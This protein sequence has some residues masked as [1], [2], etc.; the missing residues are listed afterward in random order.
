MRKAGDNT[1]LVFGMSGITFEKSPSDHSCRGSKSPEAQSLEDFNLKKTVKS[2]F[3][4]SIADQKK[5]PQLK[6]PLA[7]I[8]K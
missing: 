6:I 8:K 2:K 5:T 7:D 3:T 1:P 4:K